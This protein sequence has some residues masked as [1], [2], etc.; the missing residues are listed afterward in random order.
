MGRFGLANHSESP[1]RENPGPKAGYEMTAASTQASHAAKVL[2]RPREGRLQLSL[3]P[4]PE[5]GA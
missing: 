3:L 2:N 4:K 5:D 1:R